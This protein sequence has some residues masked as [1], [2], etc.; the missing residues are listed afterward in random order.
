MSWIKLVVIGV[1]AIGAVVSIVAVTQSRRESKMEVETNEL[2]FGP[3]M[4]QLLN[5]NEERTVE[6]Y[7]EEGFNLSENGVAAFRVASNPTTGYTWIIDDRAGE[8]NCS[9]QVLAISQEF[10]AP[11]SYEGDEDIVGE[12]GDEYF[13]L[14]ALNSAECEFRMAY[15]RGWMFNWSDASTYDQAVQIIEI[16]VSIA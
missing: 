2:K 14:K 6:F 8:G 10:D 15:A 1:V 7:Q 5:M 13:T 3:R 11:A 16:P 9:P 12:G 4:T